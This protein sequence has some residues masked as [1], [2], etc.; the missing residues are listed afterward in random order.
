MLDQHYKPIVAPPWRGIRRARYGKKLPE[1][2][3]TCR[4]EMLFPQIFL[5]QRTPHESLGYKGNVI[6][7]DWRHSHNLPSGG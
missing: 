1:M 5:T 6:R 3:T 2:E 4:Y 7:F